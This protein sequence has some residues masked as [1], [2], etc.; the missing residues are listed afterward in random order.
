MLPGTSR[1]RAAVL[2]IVVLLVGGL[3]GPT[4][5]AHAAD[6]TLVISALHVLEREYVEPVHPI[7]LLN[8]AIA[9]LRAATHQSAVALPDIPPY[10]TEPDAANQFLADFARALVVGPLPE[11]QLAY[12]ATRGMLDSLHDSHTYYLDPQQLQRSREELLGRPGFS[13]IGVTLVSRADDAG[14]KWIF[15]E[16]VVPGAP[17]EGA[18]IKRFDRIV[19]VDGSSLRNASVTEASQAIRGPSGTTVVLSVQRR[20]QTLSIS[21]VRGPIQSQPVQTRFIE[22]GVAYARLFSFSRGAGQELARQLLAL[23][24]QAPVSSIILDLRGNPGG[25]I[26]EAARVGGLFLPPRTVLARVQDRQDASV[27]RSDGTPLFAETPLVVLIDGGSASA[28]EIVTGALKEHHRA[29]IVG[30]K[31]AGALG[32]AVDVRL[33]EGGMSVTVERIMTPEG[34]LVEGAGIAPDMLVAL[35]VADMMRGED[36]QLQAALHAIGAFWTGRWLRVA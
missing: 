20:D 9:A 13:G 18:G 15:V 8:A 17:A 30:E 4:S 36:K 28:S 1:P 14:T 19:G 5:P 12:A 26:L 34:A 21:V 29:T 22:P 27:L 7:E 32:G 16:D 35:T 2:L 10:V 31:T 6:G 25:L 24:D 23:A 3:L 11:T 33:P